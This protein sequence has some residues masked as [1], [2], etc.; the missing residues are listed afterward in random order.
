[1]GSIEVLYIIIIKEKY[2]TTNKAVIS[3]FSR[4]V[5]SNIWYFTANG[6]NSMRLSL[7]LSAG[8]LK[9]MAEIRSLI[10]ERLI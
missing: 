7:G 8:Y 3:S 10:Q 4:S 6:F 5:S 9:G 1:M 2:F